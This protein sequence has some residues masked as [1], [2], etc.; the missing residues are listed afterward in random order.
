MCGNVRLHILDQTMII[1][2]ARNWVIV[3][4]PGPAEK[5]QR[6]ISWV[7]QAGYKERFLALFLPIFL[8][9]KIGLTKANAQGVGHHVG[10][11]W[12]KPK[13]PKCIYF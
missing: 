6:W 4:V 12:W 11:R 9:L 13:S 1:L 10:R 3:H 8:A 7:V 5:V 2:E